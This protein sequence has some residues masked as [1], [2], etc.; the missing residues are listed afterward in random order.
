VLLTIFFIAHEKLSLQSDI[1]LTAFLNVEIKRNN[2]RILARRNSGALTRHYAKKL[3]IAVPGQ[4]AFKAFVNATTEK[5]TGYCI[6]VFEAAVKKLPH[7]LDYEFDVFDGSY[8]E[9]VRNVSSGVG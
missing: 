7:D 4:H 5:V 8:D 3:K 9:L 1:I 2:A 6:D